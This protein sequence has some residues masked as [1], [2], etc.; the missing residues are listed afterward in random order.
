MQAVDHHHEIT[1][2]SFPALERFLPFPQGF[3]LSPFPLLLLAVAPP[4]LP[5]ALIEAKDMV[6]RIDPKP[7]E[8]LLDPTCGTGGL[9]A[10]RG[11][12]RSGPKPF[13]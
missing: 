8:S 1:P 9:P 3:G 4:F 13:C 2:P 10:Q 11:D 5:I 12:W 7:G 6:D